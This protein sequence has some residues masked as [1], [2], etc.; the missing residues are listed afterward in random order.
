MFSRI[1]SNLPLFI[2]SVIFLLVLG[3]LNIFLP[4]EIKS[5]VDLTI[6]GDTSEFWKHAIIVVSLIVIF[7]PTQLLVNWSEGLFIKKCLKSMKANYIKRVFNKN[8]NEFQAENNANYL[9]SLTND[10]NLIEKNY[11]EPIIAIVSSVIFFAAGI[12]LI[13]IV[14]PYILLMAVG[15]II[16]NIII[17]S[18]ASKPLNENTKQRSDL[19]NKYTS[20]IKEVLSAFH[21]IKTNNL[22]DKVEKDFSE[23][24]Y[25]V[26]QKGYTI[27]KILSV[28]FA[29]QNLNFN[30]TFFG[31]II[32][33]GI[34]AL[35]GNVT[36]GGVVLIV[37][38]T[39]KLVWP[40]QQFS[41]SLPKVLSVKSIFNKID[42]SLINKVEYAETLSFNG[43]EDE[44]K[45]S[46]VNFSYEENEIL[47]DVNFTFKKNKKYL[48]VGPSGGG[49]STILRLLRK[50]FNP[51]SG[52]IVI[53]E[54]PLLDIKKDQYFSHISNI[55]QQV[56]LF[57]D[58]IRNNLTLYKEYSDEEILD[59]IEKAGLTDF[60]QGLQSGLDSVVYDNGKN[61]S[62]GERSR[63]AIARGLISKAEII[64]LDEA[65]A[66][67]DIEKAKG[68]EKSILNLNNVTIINVSHVV[69]KEHENLYDEVLIVKD[70]SIYS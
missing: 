49:K 18:I 5:I 62:G 36:L 27:D 13:S 34:M 15:L 57:E 55:E 14:S 33:V 63:I 42:E 22:S 54:K 53:D 20:Y 2:M 37:Q 44:I 70:K 41:E 65:F 26:Q 6:K 28:V 23:T 1:R 16:I 61:I 67:L 68:I 40:V 52:K 51:G 60:V 21:I 56:F 48:L 10:F 66:S 39:D 50:Y 17:A 31:L 8:I 11:L 46:D 47:K 3:A 9:S 32:V 25:K 35:N 43:F 19:F 7:F 59:A 24:S 45:F 12:I 38:S 64:F 29:I 4:L 69:F 30:L 58:T